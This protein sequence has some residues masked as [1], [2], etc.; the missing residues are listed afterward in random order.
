M[1]RTKL[2]RIPYVELLVASIVILLPLA[3]SPD[4][5]QGIQSAKSFGFFYGLLALSKR[6]H[7]IVQCPKAVELDN[8]LLYKDG[9][10]GSAAVEVIKEE[11]KK[12]LERALKG[13]P[14]STTRSF[15]KPDNRQKGRDNHTR[16]RKELLG[17]LSVAQFI[18]HASAG[19]EAIIIKEVGE[20]TRI[21]I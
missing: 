15:M 9:K 20:V 6:Y 1:Q 2:L 4:L 7:E 13:T 3:N 18:K 21:T 14:I 5:M 19:N 10:I 11:M 12:R 8:E 16:S 17:T